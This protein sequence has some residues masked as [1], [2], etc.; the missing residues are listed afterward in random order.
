MSH[1]EL[2]HIPYRKYS[3]C[4]ITTRYS[5]ICRRPGKRN[6]SRPV[7]TSHERALAQSHWNSSSARLNRDSFLPFGSCGLCL[8]VARE[9]V[10]CQ[11]GDIFCRECA[12]ANILAQKKELK[13]ADRARRNAENEAAQKTALEEEEDRARAIRDF[14]MTQAGLTVASK[15]SKKSKPTSTEPTGD[16]PRNVSQPIGNEL[17]VAT[18]DK[19]AV[20]V[21]RKFTL[22]EDE[23]DRNARQDKAK[24]RK[25]IEDEKVCIYTLLLARIIFFVNVHVTGREALTPVF[26]DSLS[27]S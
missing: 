26:L 15:E 8:E 9:P 20:G 19:D 21:K 12:L 5:D 11:R 2:F 24:A 25:A 18:K 6:T 23:V 22:D 10:S 17:V 27:H 14:E 13:R 7:F 1:S 3:P 4:H 16:I